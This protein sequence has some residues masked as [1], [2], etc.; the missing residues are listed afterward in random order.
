MQP[1]ISLGL[2]CQKSHRR[3]QFSMSIWSI[4]KVGEVEDLA[5]SVKIRGVHNEGMGG[6][7]RFGRHRCVYRERSTTH[8]SV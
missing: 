8:R 6:G 1:A 2:V 4:F 3:E 5:P 7:L